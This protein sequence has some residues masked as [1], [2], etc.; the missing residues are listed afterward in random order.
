MHNN[1]T[2][3]SQ[4][5]KKISQSSIIALRPQWDPLYIVPVDL[6]SLFR[7]HLLDLTL[8]VKCRFHF[9]FVVFQ[10]SWFF[11]TFFF[12]LILYWLSVIIPDNINQHS[13]D[14]GLA[15][16]SCQKRQCSWEKL[17]CLTYLVCYF[18][19]YKIL[20]FYILYK[21]C[22]YLALFIPY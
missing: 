14:L 19:P 8:I 18:F 20:S 7:I 12:V 22:F 15:I 16:P 4:A 11:C 6:C 21:S 9:Y 17:I 13:R 10:L 2:L 5:Y 1:L 3:L